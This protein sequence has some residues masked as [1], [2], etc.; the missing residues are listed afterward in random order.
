MHQDLLSP[1]LGEKRRRSSLFWHRIDT[2]QKIARYIQDHLTLQV[3][4]P[5][6][7]AALATTWYGLFWSVDHF[8]SLSGGLSFPDMQPWLTANELLTQIR[9]YPDEAVS[10]YLRWSAF[11]DAWPFITFTTMLFISAWLL[12]FMSTAWQS[13]LVAAA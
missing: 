5:L 3:F 11:D 10:F 9:S 1:R 2:L 6:L 4:F 12:H 7:T 13:W 8:A